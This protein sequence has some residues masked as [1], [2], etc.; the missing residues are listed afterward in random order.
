[1]PDEFSSH[2]ME[3]AIPAWAKQAAQAPGE[4]GHEASTDEHTGAFA[5]PALPPVLPYP[6][7]LQQRQAFVEAG[8][9]GRQRLDQLLIAGATGALVLSVTFLEKIAPKPSLASRPFLFGGWTVLLL[10]LGLSML[11]YEAS[12]R[13]F[14]AGIRGLDRQLETGQPYDPTTNTW[15]RRTNWFNRASL[16]SFFL[17]IAL[18]VGFAF[19]NVPFN[20]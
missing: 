17:G 5:V 4:P 6:E 11:G 13:A 14:E 20:A 15:D 18:L 1:M 19:V 16:I 10:A 9:R 7:Y 8:Q 3:T 2:T 12:C